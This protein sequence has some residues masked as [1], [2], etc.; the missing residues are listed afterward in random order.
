MVT[1]K[2]G[3]FSNHKNVISKICNHKKIRSE[4]IG[5]VRFCM[6]YIRNISCFEQ[7]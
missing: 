1:K 2:D 7:T 5:K 6:K 3:N 4:L